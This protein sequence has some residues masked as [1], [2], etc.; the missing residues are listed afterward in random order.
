MGFISHQQGIA[1]F[2]LK[3]P[4]QLALI[5]EPERFVVNINNCDAYWLN[6]KNVAQIHIETVTDYTYKPSHHLD[7]LKQVFEDLGLTQGYALDIGAHDGRN[8]SNTFHLYQQGWRGLAIE[9]DPSIFARLASTYQVLP[10]VKVA[11]IKITPENLLPLLAAYEVPKQFEFLSLDIDSYDHYVLAKLLEQYRPSFIACEINEVFAPPLRFSLLP[12]GQM[13]PEKRFY[14]QSL[15]MLND[16]ALRHNYV[17]IKTHYMD[18]FLIDRS[19]I[20][21]EAP[22]LE[23]LFKTGMLDLK[24]PTYYKDYPFD[25][26]ALWQASPQQALEMVRTG[27]AEFAGQFVLSLNPIKD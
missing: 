4:E 22:G 23:E 18:A 15:A 26:E 1:R 5:I 13:L 7:Y 16:L 25:V 19:Y 9:C 3:A 8:Y 24:L 14:G 12:Q 20:Q 2:S 6:R 21:G 17:I 10:K 11:R 27:Y